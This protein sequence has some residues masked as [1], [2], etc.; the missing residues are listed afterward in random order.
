VTAVYRTLYEIPLVQGGRA[1]A[2][3]TFDGVHRGH[4]QVIASAVEW[5]RAHNARSCVVTFDPHP[6]QVLSDDPPRL[7]TTTD[8][9]IGL[10]SELDVDEIAVVPFTEAL[11][12]M[13]PGPFSDDVLVNRL[14]A[15][16][17]SV[18]EN[19]RFGHAAAGDADFLRARPDLDTTVVPLVSWNGETVSSSRIRALVSEGAVR[20]AADL[21]GAPFRLEGKVVEG[22]ARGRDLDMPTANLETAPEAVLPGI[23]IYAGRAS[24]DGGEEVPAAVS[25]G[26]RPTFEEDGALKVEAHLIGSTGDLY[27]RRL[28]LAFLERLR[29]EERFDSAE[30]LVDQM[31]KDVDDTL[32]IAAR[33]GRGGD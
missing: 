4:R 23:G 19:F 3:G 1:L 2:L 31:K 26:V 17:V 9:K 18:G 5:A 33:A 16:H 12:R 7:L 24:V 29:D 10:I 15:R 13:E 14:E 27:G 11:S 32:R 21:L 8:V 30:E 28:R 20:E 22:D 25:V 6:L